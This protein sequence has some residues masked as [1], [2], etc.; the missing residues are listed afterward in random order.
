M[1]TDIRSRIR[2]CIDP[3]DHLISSMEKRNFSKMTV[4]KRR[5]RRKEKVRIVSPGRIERR[6]FYILGGWERLHYDRYLE[7][8]RGGRRPYLGR[9]REEHFMRKFYV[10]PTIE[11]GRKNRVSFFSALKILSDSSGLSSSSVDHRDH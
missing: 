8:E 7:G 4:A 5:R 10:L 1:G 11:E 6:L 2:I 3:V 9:R